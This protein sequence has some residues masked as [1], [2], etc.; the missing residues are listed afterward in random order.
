[1]E[2]PT[3]NPNLLIF[4]KRTKDLP[5]GLIAVPVR[6]AVLLLRHV[7]NVRG[8]RRGKRGRRM[9]AEATREAEG[10]APTVS[11]V[12]EEEATLLECQYVRTG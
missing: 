10:L 1:M 7:E 2:R 9:Q 12:P 8:V 3:V 6:K 4:L 11:P 5:P